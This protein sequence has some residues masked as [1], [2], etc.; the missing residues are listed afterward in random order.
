MAVATAFAESEREALP[1]VLAAKAAET[2]AEIPA[3]PAGGT[4]GG[5]STMG[6]VIQMAVASGAMVDQKA[7]MPDWIAAAAAPSDDIP[8]IEDC[9]AA[10]PVA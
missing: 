8:A 9:M 3:R 6:A 1:T 10:R 4:M 5:T 2:A 7:V